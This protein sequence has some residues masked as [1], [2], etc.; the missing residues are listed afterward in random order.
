[1]SPDL[2]NDKPSIEFEFTSAILVRDLRKRRL[3][4]ELCNI[5]FEPL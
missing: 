2:Q 3:V 4:L 1:M 5:N